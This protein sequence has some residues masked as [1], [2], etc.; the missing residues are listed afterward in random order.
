LIRQNKTYITI[1][2][3]S[4]VKPNDHKHKSMLTIHA[5]SLCGRQ[6]CPEQDCQ[7]V[8]VQGPTTQ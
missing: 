8:Q 2:T 1:H 4:A 7:A 3:Q 5:W 6:L